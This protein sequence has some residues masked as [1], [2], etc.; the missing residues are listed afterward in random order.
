MTMS[1]QKYYGKKW[2]TYINPI[3]LE[4]TINLYEKNTTRIENG[5]KL[6]EEF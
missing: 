1:Q 4:A 5:S 6:T 3:L 2:K